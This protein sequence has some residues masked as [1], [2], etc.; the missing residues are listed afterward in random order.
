[1]KDNIVIKEETII[2]KRKKKKVHIEEKIL[3]ILIE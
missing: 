1:M 3:D 2:Q